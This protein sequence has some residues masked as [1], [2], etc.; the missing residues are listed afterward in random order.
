MT[1]FSSLDTVAMLEKSD[2]TGGKFRESHAGQ[3][4]AGCALERRENIH[5]TKRC[6]KKSGSR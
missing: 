6:E 2:S 3:G 4:L 5:E 1:K